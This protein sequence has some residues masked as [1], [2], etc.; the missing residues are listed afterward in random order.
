MAKSMG[1]NNERSD[2]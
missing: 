1:R 2:Y